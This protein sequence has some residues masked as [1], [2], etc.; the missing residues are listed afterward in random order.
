MFGSRDLT[1]DYWI[2]FAFSV[3]G[4][5][6]RLTL[7]FRQKQ[8]GKIVL[9][10]RFMRKARPA[11]DRYFRIKDIVVHVLHGIRNAETIPF[12][13]FHQSHYW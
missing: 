8:L 5:N 6:W 13:S 10:R 1:L 7:V 3:R 2:D 4:L 11:T 9:E 12:R